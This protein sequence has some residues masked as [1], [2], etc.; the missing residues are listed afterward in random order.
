MPRSDNPYDLI[1]ALE[2]RCNE[3]RMTASSD[4]NASDE[5]EERFVD[6]DGFFGAPGRE[7]SL[8][9]IK[10]YWNNNCEDDPIL[11]NYPDFDAWWSDTSTFLTP[12]EDCSA[13][14][15]AKEFDEEY[16]SE[17]PE[18]DFTEELD[19]EFS[20]L[21]NKIVDNKIAT[22]DELQLVSK[23]FGS[24]VENLNKVIFVRT[25]YEDIESYLGEGDEA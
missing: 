17:D 1:N 2:E 13:I 22:A 4:I 11:S 3:L 20:S 5:I 9:E 10:D 19:P 23:A 14:N 18:I 25:G 16:P 8:S 21:W 12:I 15:C 7:I 6:T 24:T